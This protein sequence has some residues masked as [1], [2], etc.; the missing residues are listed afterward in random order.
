MTMGVQPPFWSQEVLSRGD[1]T[2]NVV[3]E[4]VRPAPAF[5]YMRGVILEIQA[6]PEL[7]AQQELGGHAG[8]HLLGDVLLQPRGQG[9]DSNYIMN[10]RRPREDDN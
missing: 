10:G 3:N 1:G 9:G 4:G 8:E 2:R 6:A 5:P 7:I